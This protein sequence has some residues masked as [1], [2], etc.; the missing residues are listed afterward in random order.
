MYTYVYVCDLGCLIEYR[1]DVW[2]MKKN[3][4]NIYNLSSISI[5]PMR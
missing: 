3:K 4:A 2:Y 1:F 5:S